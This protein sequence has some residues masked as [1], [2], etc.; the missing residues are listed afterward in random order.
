L[1]LSLLDFLKTGDFGDIR[2]GMKRDEILELLGE[3][4]DVRTTVFPNWYYNYF[5]FSFDSE[6][7][8][9]QISADNIASEFGLV[10]EDLSIDFWIISNELTLEEVQKALSNES[11]AYATEKRLDLLNPR[12]VSPLES[13]VALHFVEYYTSDEGNVFYLDQIVK[14]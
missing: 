1:H 8:L 12:I 9:Q 5:Q 10:S 11:I 14:S 4:E 13:G 2:L 6:G 7:I 3:P